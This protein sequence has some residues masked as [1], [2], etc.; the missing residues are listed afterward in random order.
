MFRVIRCGTNFDLVIAVTPEDAHPHDSNVR[1]YRFATWRIDNHEPNQFN[2]ITA[3]DALG[4]FGGIADGLGFEQPPTDLFETLNDVLNYI[5]T[6][7][8][9]AIQKNTRRT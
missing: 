3:H 1:C 2:E 9:N 4:Y 8:N 7:K 6:H 5:K